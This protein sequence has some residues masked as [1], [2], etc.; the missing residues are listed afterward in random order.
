MHYFTH[1][2]DDI[3]FSNFTFYSTCFYSAYFFPK[4]TRPEQFGWVEKRCCSFYREITTTKNDDGEEKHWRNDLS[5]HSSS[6]FFVLT[7]K[8]IALGKSQ[9]TL[10]T[11]EIKDPN[12]ILFS[13]EMNVLTF[14][15]RLEPWNH[16]HS[17]SNVFLHSQ[18]LSPTVDVAIALFIWTV[19]RFSPFCAKLIRAKMSWKEKKENLQEPIDDCKVNNLSNL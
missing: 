8:T 18:L 11:D 5:T 10:V 14:C 4:L 7:K 13:L 9:V 16:F 2:N 1:S 3:C 6:L 17:K 19:A 12:I 15:P